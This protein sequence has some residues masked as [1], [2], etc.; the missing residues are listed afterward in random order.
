MSSQNLLTQEDIGGNK[1]SNEFKFDAYIDL[2][3]VR[4]QV[5]VSDYHPRRPP[6]ACSNPD[7]PAFSDPGDDEEMEYEIYLV[8]E[9]KDGDEFILLPEVLHSYFDQKYI[10]ELVSK[11]A[12][13]ELG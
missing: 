4:I 2:S 6:P 5:R 10:E 13:E 12:I 9:K 11:Q 7:S 8:M 1:M 3:D